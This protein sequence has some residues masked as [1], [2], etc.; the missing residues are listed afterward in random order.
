MMKSA[1]IILLLFF[2]NLKSHVVYSRIDDLIDNITNCFRTGNSKELS[3]Y[4]S[5][6]VSLSLLEESNTYS[7]NQAEILLHNFFDRHIFRSGKILHRME[8][9]ASNRYAVVELISSTE[10]FRVSLS[11][12][13]FNSKFLITDIRIDVVK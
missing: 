11:L 13:N 7:K 5:S 4:L 6:T 8:T 10:K 2:T 12:K 1:C 9:N 3:F